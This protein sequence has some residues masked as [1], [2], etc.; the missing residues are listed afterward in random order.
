MTRAEFCILKACLSYLYWI[1]CIVCS[2]R[3][4]INYWFLL[5]LRISMLAYGIFYRGKAETKYLLR[6]W[7][8]F[9]MT[10]HSLDHKMTLALNLCGPLQFYFCVPKTRNLVHYCD[11]TEAWTDNMVWS[12]GVLT[13]RHMG[14]PGEAE[15]SIV[16]L[17]WICVRMIHR[18]TGVWFQYSSILLQFDHLMDL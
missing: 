8:K 16:K 13:V 18:D 9:G 15:N 17:S 1:L 2:M 14:I 12:R 4:D 5:Y 6:N 11:F 3:L 7:N 10:D